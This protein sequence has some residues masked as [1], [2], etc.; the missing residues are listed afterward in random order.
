MEFLQYVTN[1]TIVNNQLP[2]SLENLQEI[3]EKEAERL[4]ESF[5]DFLIFLNSNKNMFEVDVGPEQFSKKMIIEKKLQQLHRFFQ[6]NLAQK[7]SYL[8]K[9]YVHHDARLE[10]F[11][12]RSGLH[13]DYK[14]VAK[15]RGR[16]KLMDKKY[17]PEK[18]QV[19]EEKIW[20]EQDNCFQ[21]KG[22]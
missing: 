13:P 19:P 12:M 1:T 11:W 15:R 9:V 8:R 10:A 17:V 14:M 5:K 6:V 18:F 3:A 7:E 2:K 22:L 20:K 16:Q 4:E 21:I